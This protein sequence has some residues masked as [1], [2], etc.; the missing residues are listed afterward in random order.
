MAG[1]SILSHLI[2]TIVLASEN[3][4]I[5]LPFKKYDLLELILVVYT[6]LWVWDKWPGWN[7]TWNIYVKMHQLLWKIQFHLVDQLRSINLKTTTDMLAVLVA[8]QYIFPSPS[9]TLQQYLFGVEE[10][11]QKA[12][13]K[14]GL[15]PIWLGH[16]E[17]STIKRKSTPTV[18]KQRRESV[19][20]QVKCEKDFPAV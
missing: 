12:Q 11:M 18:F 8:V 20:N 15:I 2:E 1:A 10:N 6:I 16:E 4:I 7:R 9:C 14:D 19:S 13:L 5:I 3:R 17:A